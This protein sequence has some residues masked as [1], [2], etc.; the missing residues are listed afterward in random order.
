MNI[1]LILILG[2]AALGVLFP[3][4]GGDSVPCCPPDC[5]PPGCCEACPDGCTPGCCEACPED[6]QPGC[7][8]EDGGSAAQGRCCVEK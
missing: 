8:D 2:L 3:A 4:A 1:A 6:C 5:C 7:C